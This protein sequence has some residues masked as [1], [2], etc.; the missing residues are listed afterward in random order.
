MTKKKNGQERLAEVPLY[1]GRGVGEII[2]ETAPD[3]RI[4]SHAYR[5]DAS[6]ADRLLRAGTIDADQHG[7]AERFRTDFELGALMG[8]FGTVKIDGG[9]RGG[10]GGGGSR[11]ITEI[12]VAARQR[13]THA[14]AALGGFGALTAR[15]IWHCCGEQETLGA[16]AE[17]I[18]WGGGSMNEHKAAGLL[19]AG[20]ERLTIHYG[21]V[22]PRDLRD[23][24]FLRG[25]RTAYDRIAGYADEFAATQGDDG[26][27][28]V[29]CFAR[30]IRRVLTAMHE[31]G[32]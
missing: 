7:A 1:E 32:R 17:R 20:L 22:S 13:V 24:E 2:R 25:Y 10:R 23:G 9:G 4:V 31:R 30:N 12:M 29:A 11:H 8:H 27:R 28:A 16:F 15:A 26:K 5:R 14:T 18:R 3:G 21:I 19:I 6:V